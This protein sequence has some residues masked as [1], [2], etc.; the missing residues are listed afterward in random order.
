MKKDVQKS[1]IAHLSVSVLSYAELT[2]IPAKLYILYID[3]FVLDST[4]A[5]PILQVLTDEISYKLEQLK[6]VENPFSKGNL[7]MWDV[8]CLFSLLR[9]WYLN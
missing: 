5:K 8:L 7:Y 4:C 9:F 6:F 3:S 1:K 2:G